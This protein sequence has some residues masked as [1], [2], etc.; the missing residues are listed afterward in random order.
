MLKSLT[1]KSALPADD[2]LIAPLIEGLGFPR[3]Q[4]ASMLIKGSHYNVVVDCGAVENREAVVKRLADHGLAPAQVDT[5]LIT[6]SHFDHMENWGLFSNARFYVHRQELQFIATLLAT[7]ENDLD[8]VIRSHYVR[9][10]DFY[11]RAIKRRITAC[12]MLGGSI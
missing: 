3:L 2:V 9:I 10:L 11:V 1:A 8:E 5:V 4:S 12:G 6:H 7:A